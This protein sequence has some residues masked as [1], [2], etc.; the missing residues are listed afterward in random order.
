MA[1]TLPEIRV[2]LFFTSAMVTNTG[3]IPVQV[4]YETMLRFETKILAPVDVVYLARRG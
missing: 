4:T 1:A 3:H 2:E